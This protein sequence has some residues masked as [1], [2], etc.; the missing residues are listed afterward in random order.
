M[1]LGRGVGARKTN[2]RSAE[3]G[4]SMRFSGATVDEAAMTEA[5]PSPDVN[6][7][8]DTEGGRE[9]G[10]TTNALGTGPLLQTP[11]QKQPQQH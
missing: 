9:K 11:K 8:H 7:L 4:T 5:A 2:A 1:L 3:E 6:Y 10:A